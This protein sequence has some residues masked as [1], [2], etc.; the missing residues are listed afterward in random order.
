M[1]ELSSS[2]GRRSVA[3]PHQL[4]VFTGSTFL[5][6]STAAHCV[7]RAPPTGQMEGKSLRIRELDASWSHFRRGADL[8]SC[9]HYKAL[10]SALISALLSCFYTGG[11]VIGHM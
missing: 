2:N 11:H 10:Y 1:T 7:D 4:C 9:M 6:S 5:A 8:A 3:H